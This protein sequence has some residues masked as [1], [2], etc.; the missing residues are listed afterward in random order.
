[1]VPSKSKYPI[2]YKAL[3]DNTKNRNRTFMKILDEVSIS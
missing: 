3:A 2:E 1:M